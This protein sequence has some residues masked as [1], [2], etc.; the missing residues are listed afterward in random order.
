M[1]ITNIKIIKNESILK[2]TNLKGFA[3]ITIDGEF[4]VNGIRIIEG[5]R[6]IF[7]DFPSRKNK[8]GRYI[9]VAFPISNEAR[10]K[11]EDAV[12]KVYNDKKE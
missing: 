1:E 2:N 11:I 10:K 7:L 9:N 4:V 6:G 5:K 8:V 3:A 12:M